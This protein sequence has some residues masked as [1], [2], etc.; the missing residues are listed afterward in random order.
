MNGIKLTLGYLPLQD[1]YWFVFSYSPEFL[2]RWKQIT[3]WPERNWDPERGVWLISE[4]LLFR[5][6]EWLGQEFQYKCEWRPD[7]LVISKG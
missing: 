7:E 2:E 1:L 3:S 5:E 4:R 6:L